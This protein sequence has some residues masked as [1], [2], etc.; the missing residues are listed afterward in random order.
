M[1]VNPGVYC[2]QNPV[3]TPNGK[4]YSWLTLL[5]FPSNGNTLYCQQLAM[6][7]EGTVFYRCSDSGSWMSW[8]E[9]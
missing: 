3:N 6:S 8:K 5:V 4:K 2:V 7:L 9:L 1:V